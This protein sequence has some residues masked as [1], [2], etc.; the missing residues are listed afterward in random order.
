MTKEE[1]GI[2]IKNRRIELG[3]TQIQLAKKLGL[4]THNNILEVEKGR[5]GLSFDSLNRICEA[6]DLGLKITNKE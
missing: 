3:L 4:A 2:I 5:R 6:L 1:V